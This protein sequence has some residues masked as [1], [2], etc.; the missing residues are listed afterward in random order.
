L[1]NFVFGHSTQN[2][3]ILGYEFGSGEH[4]LFLFGAHHGDEIE[5]TI[6]CHGLIEQWLDHYDYAF[7]T[8]VV[9]TL[10]VDGQLARQRW[11]ERLVDLN[12]NLPTK[13]WTAKILNP[14]YP[15]G[16]AAASEVETRAL[17]AWLEKEK[18]FFILSFHS[19]HPMILMNGPCQ[20][21][22]LL[23][24]A[25]TGYKALEDVGYPTPGSLGTYTGQER[26]IPTITYE[27]ER[28]LPGREILKLHLPAIN[29][30]M[31]LLEQ[32]HGH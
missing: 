23:L 15:P 24:Q 31:K 21:E 18:P 16:P 7:R 27:I 10:N 25:H 5:G 29:E 28:A 12:R 19:Y 11:N 13:D 2:V 1:K 14:R 9:P 22:A 3:P 26:G 32:K 6:L 8:V 4:P 20:E 17:V 30:L